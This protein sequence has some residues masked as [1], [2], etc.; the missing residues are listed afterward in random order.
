MKEPKRKDYKGVT[1]Y[2]WAKDKYCEWLKGENELLDSSNRLKKQDVINKEQQ[3]KALKEEVGNLT[4]ECSMEHLEGIL[5]D[6]QIKELKAKVTDR[7]RAAVTAT[8]LTTYWRGKYDKVKEC[9]CKK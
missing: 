7:E 1:T 6:R 9:N 5:K 2:G 8:E 3:I 4:N